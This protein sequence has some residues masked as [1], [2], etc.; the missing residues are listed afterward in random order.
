MDW[1][2]TGRTVLITG[3]SKG[4]GRGI[5]ECFASEGCHLRLVARSG[6]LLEQVAAEL[7]KKYDVGVET[8]ALDLAEEECAA[9]SWRCGLMWTSLSITRVMYRVARYSTLK[10]TPGDAAGN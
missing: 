6:D 10:K 4:I 3:A 9:S 7:R 5:A 1:N 8:A 2:L